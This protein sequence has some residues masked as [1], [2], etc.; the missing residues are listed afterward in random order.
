MRV[1]YV[2][3]S[4]RLLQFKSWKEGSHCRGESNPSK[5]SVPEIKFSGLPGLGLCEAGNPFTFQRKNKPDGYT[6]SIAD[7]K[8]CNNE[9]QI[10]YLYKSRYFSC[11]RINYS[12]KCYIQ[13]YDRNELETCCHCTVQQ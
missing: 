3:A 5:A 11:D 6:I 8:N 10:Y 2:K 9:C 13:A 7:G 12:T 1:G 4:R